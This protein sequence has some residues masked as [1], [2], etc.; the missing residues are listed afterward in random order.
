MKRTTTELG[1]VGLS[2]PGRHIAQNAT[3]VVAV[4][5]ELG[6]D[7][8][9]A[10][11]GVSAY[12]GTRRRFEFK[13]EAGGVR[14]FDDYGHH[15][16]EM[17]ATLVT[18]RHAAGTGRVVVL[19][20]PLRHT[21]TQRMGPE[22]ARSL[23]L[24]DAVVVLDPSGDPPIEGVDGTLVSAH[25]RLPEGAVVHEPDLAAGPARIAELV[26]PGDLVITLGAGDVAPTGPALLA[27]LAAG[28]AS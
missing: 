15:P 9:T 16:T 23:E 6:L 7:P 25:V 17:T 4:L 28:D 19:Y 1:R 27:L 13:G 3:G 20:R 11:E 14:V 10:C 26:R 18:A 12:G 8:A 24:A 21:R 5:L 2:S 22:L